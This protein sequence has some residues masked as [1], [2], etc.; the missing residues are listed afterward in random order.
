[1]ATYYWTQVKT[2]KRGARWSDGETRTCTRCR[3]D[4]D[5]RRS[6]AATVTATLRQRGSRFKIPVGYCPEHL[7]AELEER[8]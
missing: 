1:M 8:C 4:R 2:W 3:A 7:P 5:R 6:R